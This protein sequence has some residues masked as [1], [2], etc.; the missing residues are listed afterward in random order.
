[1]TTETILWVIHHVTQERCC[2]EEF[3]ADIDLGRIFMVTS[4]E[5]LS[6]DFNGCISTDPDSYHQVESFSKITSLKGAD[7]FWLN[8]S[9][10][11]A[12][13]DDEETFW[14]LSIITK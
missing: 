4:T 6:V 13:S 8:D 14:T 3:Q 11:Y 12:W 1:M 5:S 7:N 2:I 9:T 10:A